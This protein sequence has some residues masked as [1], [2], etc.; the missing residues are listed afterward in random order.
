MECWGAGEAP[1]FFLLIFGEKILKI[2]EFVTEDFLLRPFVS[3]IW[4]SNP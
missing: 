4:A 2:E 3:P 1:Q